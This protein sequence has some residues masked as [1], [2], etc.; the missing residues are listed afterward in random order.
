MRVKQEKHPLTLQTRGIID[1]AGREALA[2]KPD[3][4]VGETAE[5]V[6]VG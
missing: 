3:G 4:E 6:D 1:A 2:P 5:E